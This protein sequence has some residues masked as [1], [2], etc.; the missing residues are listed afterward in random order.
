MAKSQFHMNCHTAFMKSAN[1]YFQMDIMLVSTTNRVKVP[2][3]ILDILQRA[4]MRE[5]K[6]LQVLQLT[7]TKRPTHI[8]FMTAKATR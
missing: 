7:G 1:G 4:F 3:M 5:M 8:Q 6:M 2:L